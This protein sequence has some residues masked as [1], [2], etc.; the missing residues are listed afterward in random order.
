[1]K[2][3]NFF[4]FC[5]AALLL[6]TSAAKAANVVNTWTSG[7]TTVVLTDDS[8]LTVSGTGAMADYYSVA[9]WYSSSTAIKAV[10]ID[11]DVTRI[12][13]YAFYGCSGLTGALTIPNSVTAIGDRAFSGCSGL[14]A[15]NVDVNNANY[16]SD[17][18]VLFNKNKTMLIQCPAKKTGAYTIPNSV[19]AIGDYAFYICSG[20][21]GALTIP[22]SVTAIGDYA[23][24][25]CSGLTGALTIPNSVTAIGDYA[26]YI[27][28]GLTGALTIPNSVTAIGS[29]A[30]SYCSGLT[31][32]LT[33]PNSV[34][35][36]GG[37][38]FSSCIGLTSVTIPNSV[39]AID[40]SAFYGCSGLTAINVDGANTR[41]SSVDGVVFNKAQDTLVMYPAGKQGAYTIPNS[42]TA[43]GNYAFYGCSGLTGALTIPNSVTAI[44]NNAFYNCS[45]LTGALTIPNSVTAI[46]NGAFYGCSGLTAINVD[47]A[48]ATYSS[49]D[50]VVFNKDKTTLVM[51]PAGKQGAYTIPNSVT[52]IGSS[53]FSGCTR[54]SKVITECTTPLS[55]SSNSFPFATADLYVPAE[56]VA[57]YQAAD[58]WKTFRRI[59]TIGTTP[60]PVTWECGSPNAADAI[61][62][63]DT[64]TGVM[65]IS[66]TG[67]MAYN[68]NAPWSS[69]RT[70]ITSVSISGV[71]SIGGF[72]FSGCSG[73]TSVTIPNSVTAIDY[74]AFYGCSGLTSVTIPNSVT[75]IGLD[76]FYGCSGLTSVTIP[77][78]VTD[79]GYSAFY[80]CSGLTAINVDDANATYSSVDGVV[81]N[82]NKTALVMYPKGKQGAYT[83]LNSVTAIGD[84]AFVGCSGLTGALT[85][86][87]SVTAI[88]NYAFFGCSGLTGALTIPNSVTAIGNTAFY[89]CTGI[90][91][92]TIEDGTTALSVVNYYS[93]SWNHYE[94]FS[95]CSIDT[96]YLGRNI[97]YATKPSGSSYSDA[98]TSPFGT[99]LKQITIGNS[100]TTIGDY[101]FSGCTG[102]KKLTIEDGTTALS[103]VNYYYDSANHYES[104]SNCSIDTLYL[105]RNITYATKPSGSSYSDA[106][107][108]PFGTAL[109]QVTIGNFVTT[110]GDSAFYNCGGL[111]S[112]GIGNSVTSIG[113]SAFQNCIGLT[114]VTIPNSVTNIGDYAFYQCSGLTSIN[115]PNSTASVGDYAFY[116]CRGI[117]NTDFSLVDGVL[118]DKN[119][120]TLILCS[121][122]KQSAYIP[123]SVTT[124]RDYA[125]QNCTGL[126][127]IY[128]LKPAPQTISSDVFS[129]VTISNVYLYVIDNNSAV[130][131]LSTNIWKDFKQVLV[132]VQATG[133]ALDKTTASL[134]AGDTVQITATVSPNNATNPNLLW[135][136]SNA[137]VAIV[138]NTG[139]VTAVAIGTTAITAATLD[140]SDKTATCTVTVTA[141][142]IAVTGVTLNKTSTTLVVGGMET[143]TPTIAPTNATNQNVS[144]GSSNTGVADV[145]GTGKV[146]A[147][148]AGTAVIAVT[149]ADGSHTA[150]C[151]VTVNAAGTA[152]ESIDA[153]RLSVYPNPTNGVVYVNNA[154]GAEIKVHNLKGELL[155]T[156]R[157]SRVDLS[158]EPNGV[159]LLRIGGQTLKVVKK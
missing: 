5:A 8:V 29:S 59:F 94:S 96:L 23:F 16:V 68:Y 71:T 83:I 152:I 75:A 104:F 47:D 18:G 62:T 36:I 134:A 48:N 38:A 46:D 141:A 116:G 97:T 4:S 146:T 144:W 77:N 26:F 112:V 15:I 66:G 67:A 21:T 118:F 130:V 2:K 90:K 57:A 133:V 105:G 34:T 30:F 128:N 121:A 129:G 140:G 84:Y 101:A 65:T 86:P 13:N 117:T 74:S 91:K 156:T 54:L 145:D 61:A 45:G 32:A 149:T 100:V 103:V 151:A 64:E 122:S 153:E 69:Y 93:N 107:T 126:T 41:Y 7:S 22:N 158:G 135:T 35:Y 72:A 142:S 131:Y 89:G 143:L 79:I 115:I 106:T 111:T 113:N 70:Q 102:I 81:F 157:E 12:G 99:A 92:L 17:D 119:Q 147:L 20:L 148:A 150:T 43:I 154:N 138:D 108:S 139:K 39:T 53:A 125:F 51:Y 132:V 123:S 60:P 159:Y 9:P 50:G 76:A 78:S 31:G 95:N 124:I 85:I 110:I 137:D 73:L 44:G 82:K 28:S 155:Q 24:Y 25:G 58:G 40:N 19:T 80:G 56:A 136:S 63:L 127:S 88:G 98:T 114:S 14:T 10:I 27:C 55:I 37:G 52:A 1:M 42:V 109:K 6:G 33:I 120:T 49:V 3:K 87:N 11:E